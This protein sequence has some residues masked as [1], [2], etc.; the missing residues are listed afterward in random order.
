MNF[1]QLKYIVEVS[2]AGSLSIASQKLHVTQSALSQ[3]ITNLETELDVKLFNRSRNGTTPTDT[4]NLIIK[5]AFETL[6]KVQELKEVAF[7]N[8]HAINGTL[9]IGTIPGPLMLLPRTLSIYKT[10]YPTIQISIAEKES[11]AIIDDIKQDKLDIGIIGLTREGKEMNDEDFDLEVV[12]RGKMVVAA[13][14]H[15]S[16]AFSESVTPQE[17][18]NHSLV[19]YNDDRMWEFIDDFTSLCGKVSILFSTN[20]LDAIRNAVLENLAITIGPDYTVETDSSVTS[21][22]VV[23]VTITELVQDYP[24]MALVWSKTKRNSPILKSFV[25]RLKAQLDELK[26]HS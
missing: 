15:S 12:L 10:D 8:A 24:G 23:P 5:K 6:G 4:G 20:N 2:K 3:S 26:I 17:I 18:R 9:R 16:L 22:E 21:G 25:S 11:Q 19:I 7:S 13:S 1:E 14:K